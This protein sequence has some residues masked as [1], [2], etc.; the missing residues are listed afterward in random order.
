MP[1]IDP[2]A[3]GKGILIEPE[4][5]SKAQTDINASMIQVDESAKV[6]MAKFDAWI[7]FKQ[8]S[9]EL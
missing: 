4:K 2:K 7:D 8:L 3:K 1:L 5:M 6:R 9:T